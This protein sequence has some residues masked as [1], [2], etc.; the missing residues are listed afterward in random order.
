MG[1]FDVEALE[2]KLGYS[3]NDKS[4]LE[5]AFVHKSFV[6]ECMIKGKE[7]YERLEFLGDAILE[8]IVSE[9]LYRNY[10]RLSEGELTKLRASLVCEFTLSKVSRGLGF[11]SFIRFSKGEYATGGPNRDSILCDVFESTLGAIYLDGGMDNAKAYVM[12][13]LLTDIEHKQLYYDSK[14]KIQEYI[15]KNGNTNFRYELIDETGPE[16]NKQYFV[17]L[18]I[19]DKEISKG[20]GHNK[21]SAEQEAAYNALKILNIS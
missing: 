3:F 17:R 9:Y 13:N 5:T 20:S 21:K 6:N 1:V 4:L 10:P 18:L 7:S 2:E 12:K 19:D 16:H 15:Q 14:T 11:G 8:Y